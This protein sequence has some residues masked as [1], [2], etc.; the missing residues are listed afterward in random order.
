MGSVKSV[1][2]V[3]SEIPQTASLSKTPPEELPAALLPHGKK[4]Q[5]KQNENSKERI[6]HT[7]I[8]EA[9]FTDDADGHGTPADPLHQ[10]F[11]SDA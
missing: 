5:R 2:S 10:Q 11:Q 8:I 4:R 6:C 9:I 1:C 3:S 7:F